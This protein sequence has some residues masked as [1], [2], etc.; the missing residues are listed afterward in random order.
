MSHG[1]V[2]GVERSMFSVSRLRR[3]AS[4]E[5]FAGLGVNTLG[6][7]VVRRGEGTGPL[8]ACGALFGTGPR[9][10]LEQHLAS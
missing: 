7:H 3:S 5:R 2:L 4:G 9:W 10:D 6:M 8:I 1:E